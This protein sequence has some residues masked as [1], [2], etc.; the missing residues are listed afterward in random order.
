MDFEMEQVHQ[1][2]GRKIAT[3]SSSEEGG[4]GSSSK[5]STNN[6]EEPDSSHGGKDRDTS[7]TARLTTDLK[8]TTL[9][10]NEATLVEG[11]ASDRERQPPECIRH[12]WVGPP[13]IG[14][15]GQ[16]AFELGRQQKQ[17]IN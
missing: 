1:D 6:K 2:V 3:T 17:Q 5:S 13:R 7:H 16:D 11:Q 15:G 14:R 10:A 8:S 9:Q 4:R 12:G